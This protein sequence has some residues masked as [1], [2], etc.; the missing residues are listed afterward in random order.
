MN[1]PANII[2]PETLAD[3]TKERLEAKGVKV[4]VYGKKEIEEI[5]MEAF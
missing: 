2:Y 3:I 4:T 5:G 1:Q